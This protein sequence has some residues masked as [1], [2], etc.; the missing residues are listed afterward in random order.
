MPT[1]YLLTGLINL[2]LFVVLVS[3]GHQLHQENLSSFFLPNDRPGGMRLIEGL[4]LGILANIA[5]LVLVR[6]AGL[7]TVELS[8][9]A[10]PAIILLLSASVFGNLGVALFEEAF[11]RSYLLRRLRRRVPLWFAIGLSSLLFG[12]LHILSTPRSPG[13]WLCLL[14]DALFGVVLSL[15][16]L[17]SRSL[18]WSIGFHWGYNIL[19]SWLLAGPI[20][21]P[22]A[23][24]NAPPWA[25]FYIPEASLAI[26]TIICLLWIYVIIRFRCEGGISMIAGADQ[27]QSGLGV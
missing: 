15:G 6:A 19:Q 1:D 26:T 12:G 21:H 25:D 23:P 10:R 9:A 18:L 4:G 11:F 7:A 20:L 24:L 22:V 5:Y 14:N 17:K 27:P 3:I 2:F 13:L 16:T 8:Q